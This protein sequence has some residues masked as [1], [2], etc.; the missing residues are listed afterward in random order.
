[1]MDAP[2]HVR[3]K[4]RE[5]GIVAACVL[6]CEQITSLRRND[7]GLDPLGRPLPAARLA[8]VEVAVLRTIG[9]AVGYR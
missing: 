6:K 4:G 3:L 1:M 8:E 9:G 2:T 7:V 5:G